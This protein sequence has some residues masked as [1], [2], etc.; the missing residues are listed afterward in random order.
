MISIVLRMRTLWGGRTVV[1]CTEG[2]K[3]FYVGVGHFP[4]GHI[5]PYVYLVDVY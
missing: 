5:P 3:S 1:D 4:S 2:H